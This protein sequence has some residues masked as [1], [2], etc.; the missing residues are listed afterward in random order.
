MWQL[1][2][3]GGLSPAPTLAEIT[4]LDPAL[5][6]HVPDAESAIVRFGGQA[7][8][9]GFSVARRLRA[10]GYDGTLFADGPLI[11]DQARHAF[12]SGFDRILIDDARLN[13]HSAPAWKNA[14][15][16]SVQ[17]LYTGQPG[18]RGHEANLWERRH[19]RAAA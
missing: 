12:Q 19:A 7:D 11:P 16:D 3:N 9:R 6:T 14:L 18:S 5:E 2:R 17:D 1:D 4:V 10:A 13:R 15:S 8:G